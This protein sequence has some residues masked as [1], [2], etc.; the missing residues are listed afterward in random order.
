MVRRGAWLGV[1]PAIDRSLTVNCRYGGGPELRRAVVPGGQA[2]APQV[3]LHPPFFVVGTMGVGALPY[4]RQVV[5]Q[6]SELDTVAAGARPLSTS[7][8]CPFF[9]R[10]E[11]CTSSTDVLVELDAKRSF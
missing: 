4:G 2:G 11:V 10:R 8:V 5:L 9:Y 6:F 7:S 3:E 1:M